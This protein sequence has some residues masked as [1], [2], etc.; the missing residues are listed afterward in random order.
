MI[1]KSLKVCGLSVKTDGSEDDLHPLLHR[2]TA[3]TIH[4]L[5]MVQEQLSIYFRYA[6]NRRFRLIL[7]EW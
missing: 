1:R 6:L 3:K 2:D 4:V 5:Q 7:Q